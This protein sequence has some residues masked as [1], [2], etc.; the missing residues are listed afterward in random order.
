MKEL[1]L[2]ELEKIEGGAYLDDRPK[3]YTCRCGS[4]ARY[5]GSLPVISF[6]ADCYKCDNCGSTLAVSPFGDVSY[7]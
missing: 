7:S 3:Y 5:I 1:N 6:M 4:Q 2:K